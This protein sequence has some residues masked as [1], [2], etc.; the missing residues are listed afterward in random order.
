MIIFSKQPQ[1]SSMG[2]Q[3]HPSILVAPHP[4]LPYYTTTTPFCLPCLPRGAPLTSSWK[5]GVQ[6]RNHDLPAIQGG[7][8]AGMQPTGRPP[9]QQQQQQLQMARQWRRTLQLASDV[10]RGRRSRRRSWSKQKKQAGG[11]AGWPDLYLTSHQK[12][13]PPVGVTYN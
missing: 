10:T 1:N 3:V 9:A 8:Q 5:I 13:M 4:P 7:R 12:S 2:C 6:I 11:T